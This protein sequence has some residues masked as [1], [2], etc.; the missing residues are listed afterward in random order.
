MWLWLVYPFWSKVKV[1]NQEQLIVAEGMIV[2]GFQ[3][4]NA[5]IGNDFRRKI[6]VTKVLG[7]L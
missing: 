2:P 5:I 4:E 3:T 1:R 6:Y 7:K